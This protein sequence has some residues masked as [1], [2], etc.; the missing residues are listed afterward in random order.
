M[1]EGSMSRRVVIAAAGL[2][3][4]G[5]LGDASAEEP[6]ALVAA[7]RKAGEAKISIAQ[8]PPYASLSPSG[9]PEGYLVEVS[10]QVLRGLG[11]AKINAVVTTFD[12]M[13]PGL[14]ARQVDFVS[15]G[16]N[17]TTPRCEV[18]VFSAPVTVQQDALYVASGNPKGLAGY[19]SIARDA[20]VKA[21]F[22]AGSSQ[23]AFALKEGVQRAQMITVP[24]VQSGIATV[25]GGRV[26]AFVVGQFSVPAAQRKDVAMVVDKGSPMTGV[27][28]AF[29]KADV[30]ARDAYNRGL[31]KL[32]ADGTLERLYGKYGFTNWD[33]LSKTTK[34][35][36]IAPG[37]S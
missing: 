26:D 27:G 31:D 33:V 36:E 4:A 7:M 23:E 9:E 15:A 32:R 28:I 16:L 10:A 11:V 29:R 5:G 21:A 13:I 37:C 19:A 14:Q 17:I 8:L 35:S 34:A 3:I 22:L 30:G 2:V 24:D 1:G 25:T 20:G 6:D 18:V 12:A